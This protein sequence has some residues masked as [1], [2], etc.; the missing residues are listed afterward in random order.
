M[1]TVVQNYEITKEEYDELVK[2]R[3]TN[4]REFFD[5]IEKISDKSFYPSYAYGFQL[6]IKV[7]TEGDKYYASWVR[8]SSCD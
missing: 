1:Y 4:T 5:E 7:F 8:W 3:N 6:P 2:L